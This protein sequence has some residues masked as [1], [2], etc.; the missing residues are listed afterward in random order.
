MTRQVKY[1]T[2]MAERPL[3]V[4]QYSRSWSLAV[5]LA[6]VG[7]LLASTT[8]ASAA[9]A[10]LV[11]QTDQEQLE[12]RA[13]ALEQLV[14]DTMVAIDDLEAERV[15]R[16]AEI[17]T[18]TAAIEGTAD[19]L[20]RLAAERMEPARIRVNL[21]LERFVRGDPATEAFARELQQLDRDDGPL[22]QQQVLGSVTD[23]AVAEVARIDDEIDSLAATV[24]GLRGDRQTT[25]NRVS[26]IDA[27]LLELR[28]TLDDAEVE[29]E[30]VN[31]D[32]EW[33]RDAASRS[34]LTGRPLVAG[35]A[36]PALVVKID[37]VPRARPQAA[38][39][40]ADIVF[41][42]LVEGGL[43]RYAAVFHSEDPSVIGP[44]RSMRTTD[45]N[46]L[47][48]FNQP[49][50]AS[51]GANQR[52]T[53]AV[54]NSELINISASTGAGGAYYRNT[55]RPAP[56]NLFTS[57]AGLRRAGGT[58]G[59]SPPQIFTIR[60]PGTALP[61]AARA[62]SGVDVNYPNTSVNYRWNGSGWERSQ[63][64]RATVDT[65]GVRVAPE[66]VVV[67]FT[68]YGVS[69]ADRNSPEAVAVGSGTAWILTEGQ[70]I[71]GR[72]RKRNGGAVT[73]YRDANGDVVELLPGRVWVE[74]P[75]PGG[76]T[77]R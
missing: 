74:L 44:V 28:F 6:M 31:E 8:A 19:A 54:N 3:H 52:T 15:I 34:V 2:T 62:A 63:D 65:A 70:V 45:V 49:L 55:S 29:L 33:Y 73:I 48:M 61:N 23:A 57:A 17:D 64:G 56:H 26:T 22:Q 32:L 43:T 5:I 75:K 10:P 18:M 30:A 41:V 24:P 42:E 77:L 9:S 47:R 1:S 38:V 21:A 60:R 69:P 36:R 27:A 76:G 46:L 14:G 35:N 12:A 58:R 71:E 59:G 13:A 37:N 67:Q 11:A 72:W 39:N 4:R 16:L 7:A 40:D 25:V 66:T 68:E 20:E 51:S 53:T 50:F